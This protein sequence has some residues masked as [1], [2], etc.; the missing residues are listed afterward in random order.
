MLCLEPDYLADFFCDGQRCGAQ[1]CRIWTVFVDGETFGRFG[2]LPEDWQ[3]EIKA[4][5]SPGQGEQ[6]PWFWDFGKAKV[7]HF[8]REDCLC[9][10]QKAH[11]ERYLSN[12]C[13]IYP[14]KQVN[15]GG[16][17]HRSLSLSCP[18]AA[19]LVVFRDSPV[20]FHWQEIEPDRP[21]GWQEI[22][23][24]EGE[25]GVAA[26]C[27]LLQDTGL[28]ILQQQGRPLRERLG[29]LQ[30]YLEEADRAVEA[31]DFE[32][33]LQLA[34]EYSHGGG[35]CSG[36]FEWEIEKSFP[37]LKAALALPES[38]NQRLKALHEIEP[39]NPQG[40]SLPPL[41]LM[42]EN[43]LVSEY[44]TQLFPCTLGGTLAHN[45]RAF[46]ALAMLY[47]EALLPHCETGSQAG[48]LLS[49]SRLSTL[50]G[51]DKNWQETLSENIP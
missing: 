7:C 18:L 49:V 34:D 47:R 26:S 14:R 35:R 51:H 40:T 4:R 43:I 41:E 6:D 44:F 17:L 22:A 3:R 46:L 10:I 37:G 12:T 30:S 38:E 16:N 25:E 21:A 45:G 36:G 42:L 9:G 33:L 28:S 2:E 19:E 8:L 39:P 32:K 24:R 48:L 20:R 5:L 1:C 11:G 15:I 31:G 27:L 29:A 13:A 23:C 50:M